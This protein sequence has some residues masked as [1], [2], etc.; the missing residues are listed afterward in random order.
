[1]YLV[2]NPSRG[3]RRLKGH[4]IRRREFSFA[5]IWRRNRRADLHDSHQLNKNTSLSLLL[6][7][8]PR[9]YFLGL[10]PSKRHQSIAPL[11]RKTLRL[12][13]QISPRIFSAKRARW[14]SHM[15]SSGN[16]LK[17]LSALLG[18]AGINEPVN[19]RSAR[20]LPQCRYQ[21]QSQRAHLYKGRHH[22]RNDA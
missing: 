7:W 19:S 11:W 8:K 13:K 9:L 1:M 17:T 21:A 14:S 18:E 22:A 20:N 2:F 3:V 10:L 16:A 4:L 15:G 5:Q 12:V 6:I